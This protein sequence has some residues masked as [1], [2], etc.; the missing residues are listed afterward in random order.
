MQ[1]VIQ[2]GTLTGPTYIS[3]ICYARKTNTHTL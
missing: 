2:V 1:P 3:G